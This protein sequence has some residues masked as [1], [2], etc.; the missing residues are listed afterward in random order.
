MARTK[1]IANWNPVW[2]KQSGLPPGYLV[3]RVDPRYFKAVGK[4]L[5]KLDEKQ[6]ER[7]E[8]ATVEERA[9]HA[10]MVDLDV[11]IEIHYAKRS[12]EANALMWSLY[13]IEAIQHNGPGGDPEKLV[14]PESLYSQ[15]MLDYAPTFPLTT[16]AVAVEDLKQMVTVKRVHPIEGTDMVVIDVVITSS[17]W[18]SIRMHQHIKMQFDRLAINGVDL[19]SGADVAHWWMQW[20]KK[21]NDDKVVLGEEY[22][23][24]DQ[25]RAG[26]PICEGC[27]G[28]TD[29]V[30]HISSQGS[31]VTFAEAKHKASDWL[32]LCAECHS[33]WS[34][35]GGG[36][37]AFV[38]KYKHTRYKVALALKWPDTESDKEAESQEELFEKGGAVEGSEEAAIETQAVQGTE[39]GKDRQ[40]GAPE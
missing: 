12:L 4:A 27:G 36:A 28:K 10:W 33:L 24:E 38:A 2:R 14:T 22:L 3:L 23:T 17:H 9:E 1:F 19:E 13:G 8:K 39:D 7:R 16:K 6:R 29:H 25:Y 37:V 15:D 31:G 11:L 34:E 18:N 35:P 32:A 40:D 30:H 21:M 26:N 5:V 20:R